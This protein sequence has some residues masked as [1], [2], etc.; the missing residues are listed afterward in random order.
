[1]V[2]L[3]WDFVLAPQKSQ[4]SQ[5]E[6]QLLKYWGTMRCQKRKGSKIRLSFLHKRPSFGSQLTQGREV[7]LAVPNQRKKKKKKKEK[8]VSRCARL[9]SGQTSHFRIPHISL[10]GVHKKISKVKDKIKDRNRLIRKE[11]DDKRK[12]I[13]LL[14]PADFYH[15]LDTH[16]F[17]S[18]CVCV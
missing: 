8:Q 2:E 7:V 4:K 14:L 11:M 13:N 17:F 1:M 18:V 12:A 5:K 3:L 6:R 15:I 10:F 9:L 16:P